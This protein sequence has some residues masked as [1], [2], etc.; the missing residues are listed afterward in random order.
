M[1]R[2]AADDSLSKV[3]PSIV[4]SAKELGADVAS[5]NDGS[6]SRKDGV[7]RKLQLMSSVDENLL[8]KGRNSTASTCVT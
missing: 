1:P 7:V 8:N 4:I 3:Q 6:H 2:A 5:P